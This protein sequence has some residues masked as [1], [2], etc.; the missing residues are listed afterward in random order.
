MRVLGLGGIGALRRARER[1]W[2]HLG[3]RRGALQRSL[4]AYPTMPGGLPKG[5]WAEYY[6]PAKY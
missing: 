4:R 5:V 2:S 1:R 6:P 3:G